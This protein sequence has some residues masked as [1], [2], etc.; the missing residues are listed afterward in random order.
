MT[1]YRSLSDQNF[2]LVIKLHPRESVPDIQGFVNER[3]VKGRLKF[4]VVAHLYPLFVLSK[5]AIVLAS[6]VGLEALMEDV[7]LGV[8]EIPGSGFVYDYVE[9]GAAMGL[10]WQRPMFE[11]VDELLS[12]EVCDKQA[13]KA[14]IKYS[15]TTI[16][17]ATDAV[18]E[19]INQLLEE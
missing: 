7:P 3:P 15:L 11:Q 10:T 4:W 2:R 8:L 12:G 6:T 5:A 16:G 18:V 17:E 1:Y 19:L 13:V 14:Y 9:Q